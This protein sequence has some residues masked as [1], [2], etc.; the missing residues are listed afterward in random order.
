MS[1]AFIK[2]VSKELPNTRIT[3]DKF[4]VIWRAS[5]AVNKRRRIERHTDKS[6]KGMRWSLLAEHHRLRRQSSSQGRQHALPR[7]GPGP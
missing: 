2:G 7:T 1:P 4:H 6:L 5:A 3:F